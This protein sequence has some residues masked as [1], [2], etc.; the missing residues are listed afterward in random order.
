MNVSMAVLVDHSFGRPVL[1]D[2]FLECQLSHEMS[3]SVKTGS[4]P[5]SW[6]QSIE[7]LVVRI[8]IA[9]S[10]SILRSLLGSRTCSRWCAACRGQC[11]SCGSRCHPRRAA[12]HRAVGYGAIVKWRRFFLLLLVLL[13]LL[14]HHHLLL[15]LPLLLAL[16]L[17]RAYLGN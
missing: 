13:V 16:R 6:S 3:L 9:C 17:S 14:L 7:M 12:P 11:T 8:C 15:L 4:G 1:V 10:R 5:T 2:P